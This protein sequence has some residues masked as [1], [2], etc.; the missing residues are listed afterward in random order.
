MTCNNWT[1]GGDDQKATLGHADR[2]GLNPGVNSFTSVHPSQGCSLAKLEPTGG[3]G[4]F[5][6]FATN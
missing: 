6:C 5:Y 1:D 3:V 4:L 2:K